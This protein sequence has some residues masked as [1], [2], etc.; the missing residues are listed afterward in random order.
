MNITMFFYY[1]NFLNPTEAN[2]K[3]YTI[4]LLSFFICNL[5]FPFS[6]TDIYIHTMT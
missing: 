3:L 2:L 4:I 1:H 5:I 6:L